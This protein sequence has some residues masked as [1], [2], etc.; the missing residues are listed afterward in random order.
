MV[1]MV[2]L[3]MGAREA[4]V[5]CPHMLEKKQPKTGAK[6]NIYN[7]L[8]ITFITLPSANPE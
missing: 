7:I 1:E 6:C 2:F 3:I 4:G 8:Y 5:R